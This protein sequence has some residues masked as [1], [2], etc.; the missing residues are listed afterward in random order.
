M[1]YPATGII[2]ELRT[3]DIGVGYTLPFELI[4]QTWIDADE[5]AKELNSRKLPG[6]HFRPMYY[7]PYYFVNEKEHLKGV[8][9]HILDFDEFQPVKSQIHILA[10]LKKLYPEQKL[11]NKNRN[12]MFDKV[13]G[14]TE[15]RTSIQNGVSAQKII[16]EWQTEKKEFAEIRKKYFLYE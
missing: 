10:A 11:F 7:T 12:K 5:L 9:I 2:G 3:I 6:V 14:S 1:Y 8:Q 13:A 15:I 4:G 16:E